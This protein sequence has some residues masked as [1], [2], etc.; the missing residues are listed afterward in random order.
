[1]AHV[2]FPAGGVGGKKDISPPPAAL[3]REE[4]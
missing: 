2:G 4:T 1:M 3:E